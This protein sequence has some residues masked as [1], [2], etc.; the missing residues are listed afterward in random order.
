MA[1]LRHNRQAVAARVQANFNIVKAGRGGQSNCQ[2]ADVLD[3][4]AGG[5]GLAGQWT[6]AAGPDLVLDA[7]NV[8]KDTIVPIY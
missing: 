8:G 3:Y 7:E 5:N 4:L 6:I 2:I 1:V